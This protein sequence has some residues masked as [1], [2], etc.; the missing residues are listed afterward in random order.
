VLSVSVAPTVLDLLPGGAV[1]AVVTVSRAGTFTGDVTFTAHPLAPGM[2]VTF[3]PNP[4]PPGAT[5]STISVVS[6]PAHAD[7]PMSMRDSSATG[8]SDPGHDIAFIRRRHTL[9]IE[10]TGLGHSARAVLH[11][12]CSSTCEAP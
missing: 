8:L 5:T 12:L 6:L 7:P 1:S 10:G 4:L 2:S 3:D 9:V 11:V